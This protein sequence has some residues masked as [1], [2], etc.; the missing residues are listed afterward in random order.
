MSKICVPHTSEGE[1]HPSF[2]ALTYRTVFGEV[3]VCRELLDGLLDAADN[4]VRSE[5]ASLRF[6][7]PEPKPVDEDFPDCR[8]HATPMP[9]CGPC[10]NRETC[11]D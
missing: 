7:Y 1:I 6:L 9:P 11:P 4:G 3:F 5:P 8:C 2:A 10:E